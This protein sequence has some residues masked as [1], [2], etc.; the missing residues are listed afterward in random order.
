MHCPYVFCSVCPSFISLRGFAAIYIKSHI[1]QIFRAL[2]LYI[3]DIFKGSIF[4]HKG[5]GS[6][7]CRWRVLRS[8][9]HVFNHK[10]KSTDRPTD[11]PLS[12]LCLRNHTFLAIHSSEIGWI[13]IPL[14]PL[15]A[16]CYPSS[17]QWIVIT[18]P[19][20]GSSPTLL[21]LPQFDRVDCTMRWRNT[22]TLHSVKVS[23]LVDWWNALVL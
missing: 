5:F 14:C 1:L 19:S 6:V 7:F 9:C 12:Y 11:P 16:T 23:P 2:S 15:A 17:P 4:N 21:L 10:T 22:F 8:R 13:C 3:K 18:S 20:E